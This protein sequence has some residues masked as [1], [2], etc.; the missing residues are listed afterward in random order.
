M[1][2]TRRAYKSIVRW[3]P[4]EVLSEVLGYMSQPDLLAPCRTSRLINGLATPL[5]YG[6]VTLS[7]IPSMEKFV[8]V[9]NKYADSPTPLS[10]HVR[11]FSV[12]MFD[13][14]SMYPRLAH[15]ITTALSH[16]RNLHSLTLLLSNTHFSGM[17]R[18]SHFPNLR[19]FR[20]GVSPDVSTVLPAFITRHSTINTLAMVCSTSAMERDFDLDLIQL[21]NLKMFSADSYLIQSL[22]CDQTLQNICIYFFYPD[23][24]ACLKRLAPLVCTQKLRL[25]IKADEIDAR[26]F[27]KYV[28]DSIPQITELTFQKLRDSAPGAD[29]LVEHLQIETQLRNLKHLRV[30]EFDN[31]EETQDRTEAEREM[32]LSLVKQWSAACPSLISILLHGYQWEYKGIWDIE[33]VP[34]LI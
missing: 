12:V 26:A 6:S 29:R 18:D 22:V 4:N 34:L 13:D 3:L 5:L 11:E 15:Q 23:F 10:R 1:V 16:C 28:A 7:E 19:T 24:E 20:Y 14:S 27:F 32:D 9:L 21:P 33:N 2:L 30:L 25:L 8:S 31:F 17:L